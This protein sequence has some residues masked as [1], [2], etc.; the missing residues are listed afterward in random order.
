[1]KIIFRNKELEIEKIGP[2]L[3][4]KNYD[5]NN[6]KYIVINDG[7]APFTKGQG[8]FIKKPN[9]KSELFTEWFAGQFFKACIKKGLIEDVYKNSFICAE[10][11]QFDDGSYGL[12]QPTVQFTELFKIIGTNQLFDDKRSPL[13]EL[14]IGRKKYKTIIEGNT[15]YFGLTV[16]VMWQL[17]VGNNS[18]HSGNIGC[19]TVYDS[20][21]NPFR[22]FVLFDYGAMGRLIGKPISDIFCPPEYYEDIIKQII[23]NYPDKFRDIP[24]FFPTVKKRADDLESTMSAKN[25]SFDT[26]VDEILRATPRNLLTPEETT[27]LLKELGLEALNITNGDYFV[28][29]DALAKGFAKRLELLRD[30]KETAEHTKGPLYQSTKFDG[31][32]QTHLFEKKERIEDDANHIIFTVDELDRIERF[33]DDINFK[34]IEQATNLDELSDAL[35]SW[36]QNLADFDY[37][38]AHKLADLY[39]DSGEQAKVLEKKLTNNMEILEEI[40]GRKNS[41]FTENLRQE[42]DNINT[43]RLN[44]SSNISLPELNEIKLQLEEQCERVSSKIYSKIN[45]EFF[46]NLQPLFE[47]RKRDIEKRLNALYELLGVRQALFSEKGDKELPQS[48]VQSLTKEL[49]D[50]VCS[51]ESKVSDLQMALDSTER[52]LENEQ[53][54]V[55]RL[56]GDLKGAE[57][58]LA[59]ERK[60]QI[61]INNA[62]SELDA[63]IADLKEQLSVAK[64]SG[65]ETIASLEKALREEQLKYTEQTKALKKQLE[66]S[67]HRIE[68]LEHMIS[69]QGEALKAK[70]QTLSTLNDTLSDLEGE[71]ARLVKA[72]AETETESLS[73]KEIVALQEQVLESQS[74]LEI[75]Q[76]SAGETAKN[77]VLMT[78]RTDELAIDVQCLS[79]ENEGLKE[80][81]RSLES[82]ASD[83]QKALESTADQLNKEQEAVLRLAGDLKAAEV[84]IAEERTLKTQLQTQIEDALREYKAVVDSLSADLIKAQEK[85]ADK[86]ASLEE[87]LLAEWSRYSEKTGI[88][89]AKLETS[90]RCLETLEQTV[91]TQGEVFKTKDQEFSTL[92]DTLSDLKDE[93]T[94]LVRTLEGAKGLGD[95]E[96]AELKERLK[97]EQS[98][99]ENLQT[100]ADVI[101]EQLASMKKEA[102]NLTTAVDRLSAENKI[103]DNWTKSGQDA[104]AVQKKE[105]ELKLQAQAD[106]ADEYEKI[107]TSDVEL[108]C[109]SIIRNK[110]FP[111]TKK[112]L[113]NIA[114]EVQRSV[115]AKLDIDAKN[116]SGFIAQINELKIWPSDGASKKLKKKFDAVS[117]LYATLQ[118]KILIRPSEK[119]SKFYHQLNDAN[120]VI[121]IHRDPAWARYT[122]NAIAILGI[123]LTGIIPGLAVLGIIALSGRSYKFWE[124]SGQTFFTKATEAI[125][126]AISPSTA[127][128]VVK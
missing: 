58:K 125:E 33:L 87:V 20:D 37:L 109:Q 93:N 72:L 29:K 103:L 55:F 28:L 89:E 107:V 108:Q 68:T 11:I 76:R 14:L 78:S 34:E 100:S 23:K 35:E 49:Q 113:I 42:I 54:A 8:V 62:L 70:D 121:K 97:T 106:L 64:K 67:A 96:I 98:R 92:K 51:L 75:L 79:A 74:Q 48:E 26:L 22:Q 6:G 85:G 88:L 4:G 86:V 27:E 18:I 126:G 46:S 10:L 122:T 25:I 120:E 94:R 2:K 12:M 69:T 39:E 3:D 31:S 105:Y 5:S 32:Q 52:Q 38:N 24:N 16:P 61:Q 90:A 127:P 44:N 114:T 73:E 80:T 117:S 17:L 116:V 66:T 45:S 13:M 65:L 47:Q 102:G 21:R 82:K 9:K 59:K 128:T 60:G 95:L 84:S 77:L 53:A 30:L 101:V 115:N 50:T 71:N 124:S 118:D 43:E 40:I 111:L 83:L 19:R 110:L 91:A 15:P 56:E 81:V 1:M 36:Q 119:I 99:C 57:D 41:E 63:T 112:Y 7:K 123:I 104:L